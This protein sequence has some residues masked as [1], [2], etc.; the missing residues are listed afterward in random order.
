MGTFTLRNLPPHFERGIREIPDMD[1][2]LLVREGS[3]G[4]KFTKWSFT[5][6][7]S[8]G[9]KRVSEI[10]DTLTTVSN[11]SCEGRNKL[12]FIS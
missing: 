3:G 5:R 4:E 1:A 2:I 8:G 9:F 6:E 10:F 7:M 11:F 12:F